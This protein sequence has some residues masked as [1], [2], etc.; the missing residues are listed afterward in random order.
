MPRERV[1]ADLIDELV[2]QQVEEIFSWHEGDED[3]VWVVDVAVA[4][5]EPNF[6]CV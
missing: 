2:R 6:F 4:R 5:G 3:T 1:L